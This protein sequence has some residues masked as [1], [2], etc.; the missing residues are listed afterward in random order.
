MFMLPGGGPIE[1]ALSTWAALRAQFWLQNLSTSFHLFVEHFNTHSTPCAQWIIIMIYII[2]ILCTISIT[3]ERG[4]NKSCEN[5][6]TGEQ[7]VPWEFTA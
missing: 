1:S 2:D 6:T 4:K 5:T 7:I 3:S